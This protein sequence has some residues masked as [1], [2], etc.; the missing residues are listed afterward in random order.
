MACV[1]VRVEPTVRLVAGALTVALLGILLNPVL[2]F[3]RW[4]FD[5]IRCPVAPKAVLFAFVVLTLRG[6]LPI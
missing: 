2:K 5:A 3:A 6:H 1:G 4:F